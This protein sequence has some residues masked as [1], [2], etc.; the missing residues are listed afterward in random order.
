KAKEKRLRLWQDHVVRSKAGGDDHDFEGTVTRIVSGDTLNVRVNRTGDP[1]CPE[2]N[3]EAKEFLRK[4]LIGK[5]VRVIIDYQ[6]PASEGYEAKECATIKLG[7]FNP[8]EA[9]IERGLA[10][11]I[12]HKRDDEDRSSCYDQL[13]I[14]DQKA[15]TNGKGIYSTKE[16][17]VYRIS[18]VSEA[19]SSSKARQFL[20]SLQ[21]Y[22]RVPGVIDF[23]NNGSRFKI[24]I[25]KE[26][27]KLTFVLSGIRC[28]RPGRTPTDKSEPFATEALE[29]ATRKVLQR[30]VEI[31]VENVDKVGGFIGSLWLNKTENFATLLLQEGLATVHSF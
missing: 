13:L 1:K 16:P 19:C 21:R 6:K 26:G 15:Q 29:F 20:H 24:Y 7:E 28:P 31:E 10:H 12:R 22:G 3:F 23:V 11:I 8:A 4:K 14:A 17:P 5:P 27:Y 25:P 9:L 2:Y 30:D 18:D